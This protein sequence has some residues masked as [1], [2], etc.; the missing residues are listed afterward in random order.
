MEFADQ[1]G[2]PARRILQM[3]AEAAAPLSQREI[4]QRAAERRKIIA[5]IETLQRFVR[6]GHIATLEPERTA[7]VRACGAGGSG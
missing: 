3:L 4:R 6:E 7:A 1:G 5:E 2:W